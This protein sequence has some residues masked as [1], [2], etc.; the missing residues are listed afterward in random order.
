MSQVETQQ[1]PRTQSRQESPS[2]NGQDGQKSRGPRKGGNRPF[3]GEGRTTPKSRGNGEK[4]DRREGGRSRG[5]VRRD[6]D[7]PLNKDSRTIYIGKVFTDDL[8]GSSIADKL[9][10]QRIKYLRD[11]LEQYGTIESFDAQIN[12][13]YAL[14]T[15]ETHKAADDALKTLRNREEVDTILDRVRGKLTQSKL[16]S[17]V[18]PELHRYKYNWSDK[19][20]SNRARTAGVKGT[21]QLPKNVV[22]KKTSDQQ[23]PS[24]TTAQQPVAQQQ[25]ASKQKK[26]RKSKGDEEQAEPQPQQQQ[27]PKPKK[28]QQQNVQQQAQANA[29][30]PKTQQGADDLQREAERA[31]LTQD[32]QYLRQQQQHV[33]QELSAE[34]DRC[35][36]RDERINRLSE[37]L[38]RVRAQE[39][40]LEG[41]L[42]AEQNWKQAAEERIVKLTE[43][44]NHFVQEQK[45]VEKRLHTV[46]QQLNTAS[47]NG[48]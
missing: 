1:Q 6:G 35:R 20:S 43:E 29:V 24:P 31:R 45:Q 23:A 48:L 12:E 21:V 14:V 7:R 37:E 19:Q 27:Q 26:P 46:S 33:S 9:K 4:G 22:A 40:F 28:S 32:L 15:Y 11:V 34:S 16:P 10:E 18:C 47:A 8:E 30:S 42:N 2:V 3:D 25:Q 17:A 13:A 41:Q 44:V 5:S 39:Q 38:S 36:A